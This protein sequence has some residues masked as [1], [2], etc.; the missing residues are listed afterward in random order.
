MVAP[1][2]LI[3]SPNLRGFPAR[4]KLRRRNFT[5][6][7]RRPALLSGPASV[8]D[9]LA[10]GHVRGLVGGQVE[11]AVGD[12]VRLAVPA[13]RDARDHQLALR[14]IG[15]P[16]LGHRRDDPPGVD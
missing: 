12:F 4:T 2:G 3:P 9:E 16:P 10:S 1:P 8:D 14:G 6:M 13:E 5:P 11:N 15:A 7:A